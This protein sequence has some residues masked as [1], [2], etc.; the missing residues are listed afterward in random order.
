MNDRNLN[1]N[2]IQQKK[3]STM[4]SEEKEKKEEQREINEALMKDI[5]I[6]VFHFLD[7]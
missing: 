1:T 3:E 5:R 6:R 4:T 7:S 2:T